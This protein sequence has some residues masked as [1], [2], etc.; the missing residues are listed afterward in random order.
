MMALNQDQLVRFLDYT[1]NDPFNALW[2]VLGTA[3]LR[4][5][6]ALGLKWE[7]VDLISGRLI[8]RRALQRQRGKGLLFVP[9]KTA[10]SYR[11]VVL[12]KRAI[13]ALTAQRRRHEGQRGV[14]QDWN[15]MDL[16]FPSIIGGPLDPGRSSQMLKPVL[17][18][19]GMPQIRV[20][21]LRHTAA[22]IMLTQGVH[23]KLVQEMLGH[24]T[25]A[26]TMDTYSHVMPTLHDEAV[27]KLDAV[28]DRLAA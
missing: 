10:S 26:T 14:D 19:A 12:T 2:S 3:G 11:T 13:R 7:D 4:V 15:V 24:S 1:K 6:E 5:G 21:D 17:R 8:V 9:L 22:T 25:I 27:R 16:V 28:L 23:P 20:H 18:A